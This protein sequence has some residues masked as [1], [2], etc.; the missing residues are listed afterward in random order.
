M[1]ES[2]LMIYSLGIVTE[3]KPGNSLDIEVYPVEDLPIVDGDLYQKET[4]GGAVTEGTQ[5]TNIEVEKTNTIKATWLPLGS[6]NR[7]T[8]PDVVKNESVLIWNYQGTDTYYWTSLFDEVNL[9]KQERV[10]Y[11]FSNTTEFNEPLDNENSYFL[12]VST[13]DGLV[14]LHTSDNQDEVCTYDIIIDTKNGYLSIQDGTDN[15]ILL[16]SDKGTLLGKIN[17]SVTIET[18]DIITTGETVNITA[19]NSVTVN[20]N[21]ATINADESCSVK[22]ES[23]NIDATTITANASNINFTGAMKLTGSLMVT[24]GIQSP[25]GLAIST[26]PSAG[27]SDLDLLEAKATKINAALTVT[28]NATFNNITATNCGCPNL[29]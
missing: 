15:I 18:P 2:K 13:K 24:D 12:E 1:I 14:Q 22:S 9:R 23:V 11:V 20:T 26:T 21:T 10:I 27:K 29:D 6:S 4:V 19:S 16:N 3:D 5:T 28:G 25:G 8:P 7:V 17:R